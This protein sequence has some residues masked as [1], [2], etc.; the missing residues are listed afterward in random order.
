[1][2]GG[3]NP[4]SPAKRIERGL[5]QEEDLCSTTARYGI[6]EDGLPL[7]MSPPGVMTKS[8]RSRST[9]RSKQGPVALFTSGVVLGVPY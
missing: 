3:C 9:V 1:M 4:S 5:G 8:P 7:K 6:V 2:S